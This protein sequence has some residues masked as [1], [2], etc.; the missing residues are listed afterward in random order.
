MATRQLQR[1]TKILNAPLN[2]A[3]R[4]PLPIDEKTVYLLAEQGNTQEDVA[5][6][7]CTTRETISRKFGPIFAQARAVMRMRLRA[8]QWEMANE[9]VAMQIWLGKQELGQK[10]KVDV[11]ATVRGGIMVVPERSGSVD[12]W[13]ERA[14]REAIES[15]AV[16]IAGNVSSGRSGISPEAG[17]PEAE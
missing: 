10:D 1:I 5:A 8:K 6:Y 3:G 2:R 11:D 15:T 4:P 17:G 16:E 7:F 9:N 12:D 14:K 13:V